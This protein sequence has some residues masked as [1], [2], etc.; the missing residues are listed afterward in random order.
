M[1]HISYIEVRNGVIDLPTL[2]LLIR[3]VEALHV[4]AA[5]DDV[6]CGS[7]GV[8][9]VV[10]GWG[11]RIVG[12]GSRGV[13]IDGEGRSCHLPNGWGASTTAELR[14]EV[15]CSSTRPEAVEHLQVELLHAGKTF[16][17][18]DF[19]TSVGLGGVVEPLEVEAAVV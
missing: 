13:R 7:G 11:G 4:A 9:A 5:L 17:L 15:S 6:R 8:V 18:E 10:V 12:G 1:V 3:H 14:R 16:R 2:R 19:I